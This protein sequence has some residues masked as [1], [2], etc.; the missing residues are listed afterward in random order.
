M[1]TIMIGHKIKSVVVL[2][3]KSTMKKIY[4][5]L[6]LL[7]IFLPAIHARAQ[8]RVKDYL[9]VPGPIAF[10]SI[11][12]SLSWSS[13]PSDHYFKHEYLPQGDDPDRYKQML[14]IEFVEG[15]LTAKDAVNAK[16]SELKKLKETNPVVNYNVMENKGEYL[17]DFVISQ[18]SADGQKVLVLERN[19][20]HYKQV[21]DATGRKGVLLFGV[22]TRAYGNE[23]DTYFPYLKAHK[24]QMINTVANYR[25]PAIRVVN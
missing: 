20:Y 1:F 19:V 5:I 11:G 9:S 3:S 13:H 10:D 25:M 4:P 8:T 22:S 23:I 18:N 14:L 21:S 24:D 15:D 6:L 16:A 12:Y 2:H 17:L 7:S